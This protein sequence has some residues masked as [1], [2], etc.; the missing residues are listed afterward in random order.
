MKTKTLL[1]TIAAILL[2]LLVLFLIGGKAIL[3]GLFLLVVIFG[4]LMYMNFGVKWL[5]DED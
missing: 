3:G 5:K 1:I 4:G 2:A